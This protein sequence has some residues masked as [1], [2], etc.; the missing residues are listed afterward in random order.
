MLDLLGVALIIGGMTG[1]GIS[2][3]EQEQDKV[4][5]LEEFS[6]LFRLLKS[7]IMFKRQNLPDA[8]KMA[9]EKLGGEKGKILLSIT[10]AMDYGDGGNFSELWRQKWRKWAERSNLGKE[11]RQRVI[12]FSFFVGYEEDGLQ[13]KMIGNQVEEFNRMAEEKREELKE[14]RRVVLLLFSCMGILIALILL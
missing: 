9:G 10:E 5:E 13:E 8:C 11:E 2:Y 3:L 12:G 7:E 1:F 4:K 14:K 6:Y